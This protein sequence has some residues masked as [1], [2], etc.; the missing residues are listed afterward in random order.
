VLVGE[1]GSG[2]SNLVDVLRFVRDALAKGL[3]AAVVERDGIGQLLRKAS[4]DNTLVIE[5][6]L[7]IESQIATYQFALK[8]LESNDYAISEEKFQFGGYWFNRLDGQFDSS[9]SNTIS[10]KHLPHSLTLPLFAGLVDI[11]PAFQVLNKMN[12][13]NIFPERFRYLP[14]IMRSYP[15]MESGENILNGLREIITN[16]PR[17]A[18]TIAEFLSRIV[19]SIVEKNPI[20]IKQ[21]GE[22]LIAQIQHENGL[23][24]L[25]QESDGTLR[26]LGILTALYQMPY[27]PLIGIEEPEMMIHPQA[28]GLLCDALR[29]ASARS[30]ILVTTHSP[31][32][33]SRFSPESLRIV[34]LVDG[35]TQIGRI[36]KADM[37][38]INEKLFSGGDLL[39]IGA[40]KRD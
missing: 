39:R 18:E 38:S 32:L 31:D 13:Y 6:T 19:P 7:S 15:I 36:S 29:A 33:I 25:S 2:K 30:Q 8:K 14:Y 11:E 20:K 5:L 24:D 17:N 37:E 27:L 34:D 12:F 40:L 26:A 3:D 21:F 4:T 16:H 35:K 28:M 10:V 23:F 1:N 9:T 22:H